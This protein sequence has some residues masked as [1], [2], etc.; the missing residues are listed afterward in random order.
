MTNTENTNAIE[1]AKPLKPL[2]ASKWILLAAFI[3]LLFS[4]SVAVLSYYIYQSHLATNSIHEERNSALVEQ[5]ASQD[6]RQKAFIELSSVKR[7]D[8]KTQLQQL[9]T[10]LVDLNNR[11]KLYQADIQ[12]LQRK[13]S[14]NNVRQPNDWILSE[15][16]YLLNLA[17]RKLWLEQDVQTSID[18]LSAADQR[19]VEMRDPSLNSLRRA[20]LEDINTLEELPKRDLDKV[21]LALSSLERRVK[22]LKSN[23][24]VMTDSGN[25]DAVDVS[26][27]INDWQKNLEKSWDAFVES[28]I[29]ISHRDTPVQAL[30]SPEQEWY[31]KENLVNQFAKAQFAVY[32]EN[33]AAYDEA[34]KAAARLIETY[35]DMSDR[36][37]KKFH[38]SI[39]RLAKQKVVMKMPD[40]FKSV[41][42][43]ATVLKQ[44]EK[45]SFAI[46]ESE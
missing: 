39:T 25:N 26:S 29:V 37:T 24:L 44:R 38:T 20:I 33:Q 41:P 23:R 10:Q 9:N 13:V 17:G 12:A 32:R 18:L 8:L 34:L 22:K 46:D 35:Y 14:E 21:A 2:K 45:K 31:L 19:I 4:I 1:T 5:L 6:Q 3:S 11:N 28:F 40:Q 36:A 43:L 15:V 42:L 27:D 30:L 7:D 16:E